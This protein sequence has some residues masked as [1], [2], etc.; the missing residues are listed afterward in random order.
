VLILLAILGCA[1]GGLALPVR[2]QQ[3]QNDQQCDDSNPCSVDRCAPGAPGANGAGC[4]YTI[5]TDGTPCSDGNICNGGE[6]CQ[7]GQCA[8]R[9][10]RTCL[11]PGAIIF[12][13]NSGSPGSISYN[14]SNGP[15]IGSNIRIDSVIGVDTPANSGISGTC[16][17]C[18]LSFTT[19]NLVSSTANTWAFAPGGSMLL[20]GSVDFGSRGTVVPGDGILSVGTFPD[21]LTVTVS[22]GAVRIASGRVRDEKDLDLHVFYGH[23][24]PFNSA[25]NG[26][27]S[28]SFNTTATPPAGFSTTALGEGWLANTQP[29]CESYLPPPPGTICEADGDLC[30]LD[31]CD[32]A[33]QCVTTS[34]TPCAD[35]G[36]VCNGPETCNPSTGQCQS[37]PP[38]PSNTPCEADGN[39]C[40][41]DVCNGTGTCILQTTVT[42]PDDGQVCNG[43][44]R[45]NPATGQCGS[46]PPAPST[47]ACEA[48]G[49][50][51]TT[52]RCNGSGACVFFANAPASVG[53]DD[54]LYCN[55]TDRCDGAG[56]CGIHSGNPCS[57]TQCNTCQ[58]ATRT[59]F[60]PPGV[61]CDTD[62]SLCTIERCDGAGACLLQSSAVCPD[63][64]QVCNG[65][66]R[67][68]PTTGSC[69]SGP[70]AAATIPCDLDGDICSIDQCNGLGQC[71]F[72]SAAL[73]GTT[74]DDGIYCNGADSCGSDAKCSVHGGDPCMGTQCNT[75]QEQTRTCFDPPGTMCDDDNVNTMHDAC[76]G[77][78]MCMGTSI[79]RDYAIL[80]WADGTPAPR[81]KRR[82]V[83]TAINGHTTIGGIVC[84]DT[85]TVRPFSTVDGDAV[86]MDKTRTTMKFFR[87]TYVTRNLVTS[88]GTVASLD[89][90]T[91]G[92]RIDT[93]GGSPEVALCHQASN[94]IVSIRSA[95]LSLP[96]T[97]SYSFGKVIVPKN[98]TFRVPSAGTL[99]G[100]RVV[101]DFESIRARSGG[102]L[103]FV[104]GPSTTEVIVR[105][106]G[107]RGLRLARKGSIELQDLTADQIVYL[108]NGRFYMGASTEVSGTIVG[109]DRIYLARESILYGQIHG[110]HRITIAPFVKQE[111]V[112]FTAF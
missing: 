44:E 56:Q 34:T 74:C 85:L 52:D 3:C 45:C 105:V 47:T 78:G 7:A 88:G 97:P 101:I 18:V 84:V 38:A 111:V 4:V 50:P 103:L 80:R 49:N 23:P 68:N 73:P 57:G 61:L 42:C 32:G 5:A 108:V 1:Q 89:K 25:F 27:I 59:C 12:R 40:T 102:R 106:G 95:F 71:V 81:G 92:G 76:D 20:T 37:G 41:F 22:G 75:C 98:G 82:V 87:E 15:M 17:N 51:C 107:R 28:L 69:V 70:P 90:V 91:V 29:G 48:D 36:Q 6:T 2:A 93:N 46:G 64:G 16:V 63:D 104:G 30:T 31:R 83:K 33:S 53:C 67:C 8:R 35:D 77:A 65:P 99:P 62:G 94:L 72:A 10:P 19:G 21:G 100:G 11:L 9:D 39:L 14:G 58:E 26:A 79:V 55:G 13:R 110:Q 24:G 112:P 66:E 96:A 54:G 60:D 86:G 43:P 109:A